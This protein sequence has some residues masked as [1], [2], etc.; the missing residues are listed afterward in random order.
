MDKINEIQTQLIDYLKDIIC[1]PFFKVVLYVKCGVGMSSVRFDLRELHT[2]MVIPHESFF[3]RY[4]N[5]KY[6]RIDALRKLNHL[7][8][9]LYNEYLKRDGQDKIW[10]SIVFEISE[11]GSFNIDYYYEPIP[12]NI[13]EVRDYILKKYLDCEYKYIE[14][15]Y[16]SKE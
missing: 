1:V 12:G 4:D 3:Q 6:K 14:S 16:P 10:H 2:N 8:Y 5:Q 9:D 11:S 15:K 7:S 13:I